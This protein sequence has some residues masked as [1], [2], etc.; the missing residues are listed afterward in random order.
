M[1]RNLILSVLALLSSLFLLGAQ[2]ASFPIVK[3]FAVGGQ[4]C[5]DF[6]A[7]VPDGNYLVT[8]TLGDKKKAART[9][10]KAESRRLMLYDIHTAKGE[11]RELSFVVNKRDYKI[12]EGG[13]EAGKVILKPREGGK[14]NWD[15]F[16]TIEVGGE[17]PALSK[18]RIEP[19]P[20]GV[21]TIFLCGDSTVVDQDNEPWASWGQMFP[22]FWNANIA[23]ANYAESGERADTFIGAGRLR[24]VLSVLQAG[25]YV[26]VEFGHNDQKIDAQP[27]KGAYYF[28]S[29]QLK[30]FIDQVRA[31]GGIPVLVSPTHRRNFDSEGHIVETHLDYPEAMEWLARRE[32]VAF[33]DLHRMSATFYEAL[34]VEDSKSAF[35]HFKAGSYP[36]MP[37]DVAD[38]THFNPYGA[39]ELAKCV[40]G[41]MQSM[42]LPIA[43]E[44][45]N[46]SGFNPSQPD[47]KSEFHWPDSPWRDLAVQ[48]L[49]KD[50]KAGVDAT[51][52]AVSAFGPSD[53]R[54]PSLRVSLADYGGRGDAETLNTEAFRKAIGDLSSRGG[55]HLDVPAGVWLTGPIE[56]KS[57]IDLHLQKDA[58]VLFSPDRSLYKIVPPDEGTSG[59]RCVAQISARG[60]RNFSIT[61]EGVFDGNGEVW[62]PVK[63]FK[64][65]SVEWREFQKAG[66]RLS[67]DGS[68]WYPW[69]HNDELTLD[70]TEADGPEAW[71][72][73]RPRML[74]FLSCKEFVLDGVIFQNSP[75]FHVN[76]MLCDRIYFK[77]IMVRCPW[78]AQNGDG[79]DLSSCTNAHLVGCSVDAG[80]DA[81]CLK[82][83]V[84]KTGRDRGPCENILIEDC[85]VFH[86]H[87]GFVIGSDTAG[88]IRNVTVR[89]CRFIDT[90]TGIR[91]KSGRGRGGLVS[92]IYID[93]IVMNDIADEAILLD[94]YY[95]QK[96]PKAGESDPNAGEKNADT[97][98]FSDIH[99]SGV[100][101]RDADVAVLV[102]GLPE[103][104]VQNL[105][106]SNSTIVS[107]LGVCANRI[108][109]LKLEHCTIANSE[110]EAISGDHLGGLELVR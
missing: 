68:I 6:S 8:V 93:D 90:D 12:R 72:N 62:R 21:R 38:N 43:S 77:G 36:G 49:E 103:Q 76:L 102:N 67:D 79:I 33:I 28:F 61:G 74:R 83:G 78:N 82:S 89:R 42:G 73:K 106:I 70:K 63:K 25:D 58:I 16:L 95:Q 65:S 4:T 1:I 59:R 23:I 24:K 27:G 2:E 18:I 60:Q 109:G 99:I 40:V 48:V 57:N 11:V 107:R 88:G 37:S 105:S 86:G 15:D 96:A 100:V 19:A 44:I 31:K 80:D 41:A 87:G 20:Q 39:Y 50:D 94:C 97:P 101:C 14:L 69:T 32:G 17:A 46:F 91:I 47:P 75:S 35:V 34:G 71:S 64:V 66:G 5:F 52:G 10:V 7:K 53:L 55:G 98:I 51:L 30:I 104:S 81:I 110:G 29:Q 3:E 92:G 85:T 56:M 13:L 108:C 26:F 84:G 9:T 54:I 45:V 22:W